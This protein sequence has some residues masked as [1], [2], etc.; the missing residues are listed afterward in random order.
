[1]NYISKKFENY[2]KED[3]KNFIKKIKTSSLEELN[4]VEKKYL[5][6]YLTFIKDN[7]KIF[8]ASFNNPK[9]MNAFDKYNYLK[10]YI[11]IPILE[12]F[13]IAEKERNY[14]VAFYI[15]GIMA[16][17]KEWL[18]KNCK[19]NIEDIEDVIIKCVGVYK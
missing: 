8:K 16:I 14:L 3:S 1:M 7:Q 6:P 18:N 19:D 11:L 4:L 15:N 2:F 13:N 5:T 9:G 12:R 17:I 10:D